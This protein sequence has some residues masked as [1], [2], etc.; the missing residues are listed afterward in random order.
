MSLVWITYHKLKKNRFLATA[1][2]VCL[3]LSFEF[4][5]HN[6][7]LEWPYLTL[8]NGFMNNTKLIQW[9]EFTGVLGG[10]FWILVVNLLVF[11]VLK[12]KNI[13]YILSL[14]VVVVLPV[15]VSFL[16]YYSY[17]DTGKPVNVVILQ[18]NIDPFTD[19]FEQMPEI[20]QV[21]VLRELANSGVDDSTDFIIAPETSFPSFWE[22][23]TLSDYHF[24]DLLQRFPK[25]K[26][27]LGTNTLVRV[28]S[29]DSHTARYD[30]ISD[31]WYILYNSAILIDSIENMQVYHKSVLV[32]GVEK[33]PY[34]KYFPFAQK[35]IL[36]LGGISGSLGAGN[37]VSIFK[38]GNMSVA[39]VICYESL[40][41][42]YISGQVRSGAELIFV[43]TNDG[44]WKDT[45]G[46]RMHLAFSKLRAVETRC[47]VARSANTGVSAII[48]PKGVLTAQTAWWE[49]TV[50]K[51]QMRTN[52][53][54]TFYVRY[55]DY[56]GVIAMIG[57]LIM[58]L[59]CGIKKLH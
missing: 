31:C 21:N 56:I 35:F 49:R 1:A 3:W 47:Y 30:S 14:S 18:P 27:V 8:G 45:P 50:L 38:L 22:D 57:L 42:E 7:D 48:D 43:I 24:K 17:K 13:A 44:W 54:Q 36:N 19:K 51:G 4:L 16:Q 58:A 34:S 2:L 41:G 11:E 33:M 15:S 20:L 28:S 40:F 29:Q 12:R 6:W 53:K 32:P 26:I 23:S 55:G 46:Y 39:P 59:I 52:D 10:S 37:S 9:Y 5:H 25:L